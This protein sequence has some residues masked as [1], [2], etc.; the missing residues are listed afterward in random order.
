MPEAVL[1]F[2]IIFLPPKRG[3]AL[4]APSFYSW[5][6]YLWWIAFF[7]HVNKFLTNGPAKKICQHNAFGKFKASFCSH[8][9]ITW[10]PGC[11]NKTVEIRLITGHIRHTI[12]E[13][14]ASVTKTGLSSFGFTRRN[15]SIVA[16]FSTTK[17]SRI[18]AIGHIIG[19]SWNA[20][21]KT[22]FVIPPLSIAM[23]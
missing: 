23:L 16:S 21:R 17:Y 19:I 12:I 14:I 13:Q 18:H 22:S 2:F 4:C 6:F 8:T 1:P 5:W 20:S 3:C 9:A 10:F 7:T 11:A 15:A